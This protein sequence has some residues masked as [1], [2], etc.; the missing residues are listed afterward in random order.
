MA[1]HTSHDPSGHHGAEEVAHGPIVH[2]EDL[3]VDHQFTHPEHHHGGLTKYI[4]VFL[5]LCVLTGASFFTYSN[6]W[7]WKDQ[8]QVGWAFMMAVSCTKAMLVILFFMH[9]KYE[10][11]WKYVLTIPAGMMSIFLLLMLVPDIGLRTHHYSEERQL[12]TGKPIAEMMAEYRSEGHDGDKT[13]KQAG[14]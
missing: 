9:V 6:A 1:D 10:A 11:N 7:P 12:Y 14:H 13:A 2:R 3:R 5:A 4:F 8:P